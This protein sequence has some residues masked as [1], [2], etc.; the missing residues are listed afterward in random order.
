[1]PYDLL[2][3]L[4]Q[5]FHEM[6]KALDATSGQIPPKWTFCRHIGTA[7]ESQPTG[8]SHSL[9]TVGSISGRGSSRCSAIT[10]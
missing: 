1:M 5:F 8:Q 4:N 9:T 2:Y 7:R 6:T 3:T 10:S